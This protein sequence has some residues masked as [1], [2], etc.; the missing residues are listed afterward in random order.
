MRAVAGTHVPVDS[1]RLVLPVDI[2]TETPRVIHELRVLE[3]DTIFGHKLTIMIGLLGT[4]GL[5]GDAITAE[6]R[7]RD[8]QATETVQDGEGT[9][10]VHESLLDVVGRRWKRV[11]REVD[12]TIGIGSCCQDARRHTR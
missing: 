1:D 7:S 2:G 11:V 5:P 12:G 4:H 3:Q 8:S 6:L 9:V 10:L